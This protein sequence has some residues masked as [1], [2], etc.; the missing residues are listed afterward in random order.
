MLVAY[1]LMLLPVIRTF[2]S[3]SGNF[4][5]GNTSDLN[6]SGCRC[7]CERCAHSHTAIEVHLAH[8]IQWSTVVG[9][10]TI[11]INYENNMHS[12]TVSSR[13]FSQIA[14]EKRD[15]CALE[16]SDMRK[17]ELQGRGI[18]PRLSMALTKFNVIYCPPCRI[19]Q[20]RQGFMS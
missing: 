13:R 5:D 20:L 1:M 3:S 12:G 15:L 16:E 11:T 4:P 8:A 19:L 14:R 9:R 18:V 2:P 17:R 10:K 6:L 7:V